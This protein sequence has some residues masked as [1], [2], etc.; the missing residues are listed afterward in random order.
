MKL[1]LNGTKYELEKIAKRISVWQYLE[2][3]DQTGI[4][5]DD[6][7]DGKLSAARSLAAYAFLIRRHNGDEVTF[8][9]AAEQLV[10]DDALFV[11][12]DVEVEPEA[13]PT[14]APPG[15]DRGEEPPAVAADAEPE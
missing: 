1:I 4:T 15:S 10:P 12:E 6:L 5:V 8:R 9:E 3:E 7:Q 13:D 11:E 2:L 14:S